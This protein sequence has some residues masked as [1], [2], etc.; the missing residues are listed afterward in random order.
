MLDVSNKSEKTTENADEK[1]TRSLTV[2]PD[3]PLKDENDNLSEELI[4]PSLLDISIKDLK[5]KL[6]K[7]KSDE[8][9]ES[10][11]VRLLYFSKSAYEK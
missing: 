8:S 6:K 2:H 3:Q 4:K 7:I 11:D 9:K 5:S 1:R 10:L